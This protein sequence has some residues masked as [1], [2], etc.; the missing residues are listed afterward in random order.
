VRKEIDTGAGGADPSVREAADVLAITLS[1]FAPH[2]A[3]D[4]WEL[5]GHEPFVG[6]QALPPA[7]GSLLIEDTVT[8]VVQINGKVKERLE[9][10]PTISEAELSALAL[11]SV[12]ALLEGKSVRTTIVRPPKLV[13]IVLG[14]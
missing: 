2:A 8:A 3:E 10:P 9:V 6:L 11:E 13:N 14:E 12:A 5:L 4:M 7:D 1:M